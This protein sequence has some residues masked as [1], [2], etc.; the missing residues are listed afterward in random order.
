MIQHITIGVL[1]GLV[2]WSATASAQ[3]PRLEPPPLVRFTGALLPLEEKN[4]SRLPTLTVFMRGER[5]IFRIAKVQK[6]TG[7]SPGGW[8]LLR[9]L[10]PPAVHFVGPKRLISLLQEPEIMG[11]RI[12]IEGRLYIGSRTFFVQIVEEAR[13]KPQR[14]KSEGFL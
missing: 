11:K 3:M 9:G 10:F 5:L 8:R 4:Q 7:S 12:N 1:L 13:E 14:L 6:L 2:L